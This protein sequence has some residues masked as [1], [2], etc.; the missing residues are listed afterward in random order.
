MFVSLE[1]GLLVSALHVPQL[2][3]AVGRPAC[4]RLSIRA[5]GHALDRILVSSVECGLLVSAVHIP[6]LDRVVR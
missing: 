6:E 3:R 4:E 1:G 5:P 2:D